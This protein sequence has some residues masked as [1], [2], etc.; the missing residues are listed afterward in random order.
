MTPTVS[1]SNRKSQ[2]DQFK[3]NR[4]AL[5]DFAGIKHGKGRESPIND[6]M[7]NIIEEAKEEDVKSPNS[8]FINM[9]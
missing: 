1:T 7:S 9:S 2:D 5:F 4:R 6:N 3:N 8:R